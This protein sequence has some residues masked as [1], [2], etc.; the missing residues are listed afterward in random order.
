MLAPTITWSPTGTV[1]LLPEGQT[2]CF[3]SYM[4]GRRAAAR[5]VSLAD[6]TKRATQHGKQNRNRSEYMRGW[7][8][9]NSAALGKGA[10]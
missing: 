5:G 1:R 10:F 7:Y 9:G 4:E 6:A 8:D 3:R 2:L